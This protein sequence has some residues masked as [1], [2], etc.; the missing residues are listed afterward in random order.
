MCSSVY[1]RAQ[2]CFSLCSVTPWFITDSVL[3]TGS[4]TRPSEFRSSSQAPSELRQQGSRSLSAQSIS[5]AVP[6][7]PPTGSMR[8]T[9]PDTPLKGDAGDVRR[10]IESEGLLSAAV[11]A[12]TARSGA[13]LVLYTLCM[14]LAILLQLSSCHSLCD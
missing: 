11:H 1:D 14:I 6:R 13:V 10:S 4:L 2:L 8:P 3:S 12:S 5:L 7:R 9:D